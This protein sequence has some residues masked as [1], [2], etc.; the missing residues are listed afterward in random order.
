MGAADLQLSLELDG[1]AAAVPGQAPGQAFAIDLPAAN[2]AAVALGAARGLPEASFETARMSPGG[3][4]PP[5]DTARV[6][7]LTSLQLG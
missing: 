6:L 7:G 2:R 5:V 1:L 4:P 3:P